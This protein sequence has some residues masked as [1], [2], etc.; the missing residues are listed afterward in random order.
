M[1]LFM[2]NVYRIKKTKSYFELNSKNVDIESQQLRFNVC[3]LRIELIAF[4]T[5]N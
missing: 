3:I 1:I 2:Y 5:L 4:V